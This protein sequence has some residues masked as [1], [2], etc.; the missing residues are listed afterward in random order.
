[1]TLWTVARQAPL[2]MGSSRQEYW[3]GCRLLLS[4]IFLT[5]ESNPCL[6]QCRWLLYLLSHHLGMNFKGQAAGKLWVHS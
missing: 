1:M 4:G 5:W 6:L 2:S 3:S